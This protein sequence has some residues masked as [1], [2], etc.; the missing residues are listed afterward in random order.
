MSKAPTAERNDRQRK[1]LYR[2]KS[3]SVWGSWRPKK[4]Y[5]TKAQTWC[6][7]LD[8]QIRSCAAKSGLKYFKK[9]GGDGACLWESPFSWPYLAVSQDL[10]SDGN[11]GYH[12]MERHWRL[13]CDQWNDQSHGCACDWD[14]MLRHMGIKSFW[15]LMV[16]SYNMPHGPRKGDDLRLHQLKDCLE[17]LYETDD[18]NEVPLFLPWPSAS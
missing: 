14:Q 5:R 4:A 2:H 10:G 11:C 9:E 12:A 8:N 6:M 15:V 17:S 3:G 18:P 7:V 16:V 13:N 1:W